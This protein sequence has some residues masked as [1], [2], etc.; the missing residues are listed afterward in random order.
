MT[1]GPPL[2]RGRGTAENPENRYERIHV[3]LEPPDESGEPTI[4]VATRYFRDASR[5]ILAEN[6]SP[7][8]GFRW[9]LNPYRGCEHGCTYCYARPTH[10]YLG[11]SAGLDFESRIMVKEDAPVLLRQTLLAPSWRPE[12]IAL[13]GNTDCYQPAERRFRLTRRCLEVLCEF[14]NPVGI[15]TKSALVTRD[16]DVLAELAHYD[17]VHVLIS[18]TTLDSDLSHSLE[19]RAA[20]PARRLETIAQL[21]DAR[22]PVGVIA[23]PIIPSLNDSEIP[24]ILEHAAAAGARSASW[25]LLRLPAPVD[26]LFTGWL[27]RHA[28]GRA[29]RVLNRIRDSRAGQLSDSR[30]GHRMRG[31]GRYAEQLSAL[32]DVAARRAGLDRPLAP[33][34]TAHFHR[35]PQAGAQLCLYED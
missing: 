2:P 24:R 11:F 31:E 14:R 35:P 13:S 19:P 15:V 1:P 20:T 17:A 26:Q 28:P 12:V 30:F 3:E 27:E 16:L 4:G 18:V 8:I 6:E 25:T 10:E 22:I 9:S 23:A 32:F 5:T 34:S 33:A 29:A 21:A 7:D